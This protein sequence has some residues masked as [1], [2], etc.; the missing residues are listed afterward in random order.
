[1]SR[2]F[3]PSSFAAG[4]IVGA[5]LGYTAFESGTSFN[6]FRASSESQNSS[7]QSPATGESGT[8]SVV[9]QLAGDSVIVESVTVPPPGVWVAVREIIG[10]DLGNVLG[11]ARVSA[12]GTNVS[13]SLLRVTEPGQRYAIQLYRDNGDN[14]FDLSAD[15]VYVDVDTGERVVAFFTTN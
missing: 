6:I 9:D 13:I 14:S 10:D 2:F 4:I 1:M 7:Y 8:V 3:S 5:L 11:A 15:S 12:P